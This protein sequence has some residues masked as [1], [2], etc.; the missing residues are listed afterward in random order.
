MIKSP[1]KIALAGLIGGFA[2]NGVLGAIFSSPPIQSILYD[3]KIQSQLFMEVTLKRNIPVSVTG[4]VLLSVI[5]AWLFNIF[6]PSIPGGTWFRQGLFWGLT[7]FLMFWLF[8]EW[9]IY[10]TLLGEPLILNLL[11]L[12][13]LL[14][15]SLVEGVIIAFFLARN[16]APESA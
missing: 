6:Q 4:L 13:I 2:G 15:G 3:P 1:L 12:A 5:H 14:P 11:E 7:I 8:Q 16:E 9:F 10:H